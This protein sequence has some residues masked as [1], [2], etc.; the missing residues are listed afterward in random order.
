V[1]I[2]VLRWVI[3][4]VT[5][6]PGDVCLRGRG[7]KVSGLADLEETRGLNEEGTSFLGTPGEGLHRV[8]L[9]G[10]LVST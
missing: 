3:C 10:S 5:T 9:A 1:N 4:T 7:W 8:Q 2:L 6:R